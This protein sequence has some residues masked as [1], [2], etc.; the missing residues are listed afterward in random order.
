MTEWIADD[1]ASGR[2]TE[3][4]AWLLDGRHSTVGVPWSRVL[5][6]AT[7]QERDGLRVRHPGVHFALIERGASCGLRYPVVMTAGELDSGR[8]L[9]GLTGTVQVAIDN[10]EFVL[11]QWLGYGANVDVATVTGP[12]RRARPAELPAAPDTW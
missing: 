4:L 5:V 3:L 2:T 6:V 8:G 11:A 7:A 12:A 9:R 10:V 1:R